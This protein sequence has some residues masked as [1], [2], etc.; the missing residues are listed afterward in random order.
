MRHLADRDR[1][2]GALFLFLAVLLVLA[3]LVCVLLAMSCFDTA[4]HVRELYPWLISEAEL[5]AE[6]AMDTLEE[7]QFL[8]TLAGILCL[9]LGLIALAG[10]IVLARRGHGSRRKGRRDLP[11]NKEDRPWKC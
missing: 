3:F 4:W 1:W 6:G 8:W 11:N 7:K 2:I 9:L 10:G 5:G